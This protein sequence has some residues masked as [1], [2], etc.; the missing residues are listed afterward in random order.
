VA[1]RFC[2]LPEGVTKVVVTHHPF[3]VPGEYKENQVVGRAAKAM[4]AFTRCG[5]DLFLA[6]HLHLSHAES[7]SERYRMDGVGGLV[8]QAGTA[9]ST[10]ERG[11]TN[12]FNFLRVEPAAVTIDRYEWDAGGGNFML[13][14]SE[15]Y[16]HD[17]HDWKTRGKVTMDA[18]TP[19]GA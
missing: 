17:G 13:G 8:V 19:P 4:E 14:H 11:E 12:S 18:P 16:D 15:A 7:T 9:T 10:R 1:A 2:A 3:D 5:A 6:G